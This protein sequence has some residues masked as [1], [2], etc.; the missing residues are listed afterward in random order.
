[1]TRIDR[2]EEFGEEVDHLLRLTSR[3]DEEDGDADGAKEDADPADDDTRKDVPVSCHVAVG[4]RTWVVELSYSVDLCEPNRSYED[5]H[6]LKSTSFVRRREERSQ[7]LLT[8]NVPGDRAQ[9]ADRDADQ[10]KLAVFLTSKLGARGYRVKDDHADDH[11]DRPSSHVLVDSASVPTSEGNHD[12][13]DHQ[14][15]HEYHQ[16][17]P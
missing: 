16:K 10:M 8:D 7:L 4:R 3:L 15:A 12:I 9:V 14:N 11:S 13:T 1:M 5:I 2:L 6:S 17:H